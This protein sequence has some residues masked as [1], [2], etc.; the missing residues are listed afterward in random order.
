MYVLLR[1]AASVRVTSAPHCEGELMTMTKIE[2]LIQ[3]CKLDA[4]KEALID[5][6][7]AD[8]TVSQVLGYRQDGPTQLF[9]GTEYRMSLLPNIKIEFVLTD[10][11]LDDAVDAIVKNAATGGIGD[12]K[13]FMS[14]I[15]DIVRIR[16]Q[17]RGVAAL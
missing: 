14:K 6:G 1:D 11:Q 17:Q 10:D 3:P 12:G 2:A 15:D 13:I 7:I 16:N 8:M 9:R 4:V 5:L